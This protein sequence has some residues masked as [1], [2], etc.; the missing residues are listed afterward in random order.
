MSSSKIKEMRLSGKIDEAYELAINEYKN[1]NDGIWCKRNLVWVLDSYLKKYISNLDLKGFY[2]R[3]NEIIKLDCSSEETILWKTLC[4]RLVS[5]L[6]SLGKEDKL[7]ENNIDLIFSMSK[8]LKVAKPSESF[9]WLLKAFHKYRSKYS[10]MIEFYDWWNFKNLMKNDFQKEILP[11]GKRQS[12]SLSEGVHIAY[13]KLLLTN[14]INKNKIQTFIRDL[15]FLKQNDSGFEWLDYYIVKL[16]VS[17]GES[18]SESLTTLLSLAKRKRNEFWIWNLI[19]EVLPMDN[20]EGRLACLLRSIKCKTKPEFLINVKRKLIKYNIDNGYYFDAKRIIIDLELLLKDKGY[21]VPR[22]FSE[23]KNQKWFENPSKTNLNSDI[24]FMSISDEILYGDLNDYNAVITY[25]D[26]S[27]NIA[28]CVYGLEKEA[29]FKINNTSKLNVGDFISFKVISEPNKSGFI[30]YVDLK[31]CNILNTDFY[32]QISGRI[33]IPLGKKFGFINNVFVND[34][35][36]AE[37]RI[38]NNDLIKGGCVFVYN[39]KKN[40][41]DWKCI[42]IITL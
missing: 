13:A 8:Y 41:W 37:N 38:V 40:I 33:K 29:K 7:S 12:V 10:K 21:N 20:L 30:N 42:R 32:K 5:L 24:D 19:E 25:V 36:I 16:Q 39:K 18:N 28:F 23:Y 14:D 34:N 17:V 15:E 35:I 27:R 26:S 2:L 3:Y 9:S 6:Y 11:N 22:I 31:R 1:A 4:S